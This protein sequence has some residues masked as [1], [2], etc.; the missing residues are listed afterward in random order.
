MDLFSAL[1]YNSRK[2]VAYNI[3]CSEQHNDHLYNIHIMM[4][5]S[6]IGIS[7]LLILGTNYLVI[8]I[9][10]IVCLFGFFPS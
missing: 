7:T 6:Q 8:P 2:R 9:L 1:L 4:K 3:D 10:S 5:S